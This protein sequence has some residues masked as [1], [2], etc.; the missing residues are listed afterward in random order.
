MLLLKTFSVFVLMTALSVALPALTNGIPVP[1][2][3]LPDSAGQD[4]GV[5]NNMSGADANGAGE[6][7]H[8]DQE[9]RMIDRTNELMSP[10]SLDLSFGAFVPVGDLAA[11]MAPAFLTGVRGLFPLIKILP[12]EFR[13]LPPEFL[14]LIDLG[15]QFYFINGV[16][17]PGRDASLLFLSFLLDVAWNIPLPVRNLQVAVYNG[18]GLTGV[19][20][21]VASGPGTVTN[22]SSADFTLRPGVG[23]R[24][25]FVPHFLVRGDL[26]FLACFES[27]IA[28]GVILS[29]GVGY[30][31]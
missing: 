29:L 9:I 30:A 12:Q 27:V 3:G 2:D 4:P 20:A 25:E 26:A 24:Y 19:I 7:R 5:S 31:F 22:A 16:A 23:I 15:G 11:G 17:L 13:P 14:R 6:T 28:A 21:S 18:L 10:L 8:P 1:R